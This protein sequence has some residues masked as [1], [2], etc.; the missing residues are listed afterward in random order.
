VNIVRDDFHPDWN[1]TINPTPI[2]A[3]ITS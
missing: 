3:V 1:Y 2:T